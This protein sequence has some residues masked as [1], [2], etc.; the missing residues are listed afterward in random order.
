[1]IRVAVARYSEKTCSS[2]FGKRKAE[3]GDKENYHAEELIIKY[4]H[5]LLEPLLRAESEK[6]EVPLKLDVSKKHIPLRNS[7]RYNFKELFQT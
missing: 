2:I 1:M 7:S 5:C 6:R 3:A 4:L